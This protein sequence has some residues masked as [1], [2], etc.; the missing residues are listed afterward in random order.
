MQRKQHAVERILE[1]ESLTG[2]LTDV[3][4][5]ALIDWAVAQVTA[6][7]EHPG[8]SDEALRATTQAVRHAVRDAARSGVADPLQLVA[9]AAQNLAATALVAMPPSAAVPLRPVPELP[10]AAEPV[11]PGA[12]PA[13]GTKPLAPLRRSQDEAAGSSAT[14]PR[15]TLDATL[16]RR[17]S[18][19]D[20]PSISWSERLRA[21][22]RK[23]R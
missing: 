2:G 22:L 16:Q 20:Q 10:L 21:W 23:G 1:D 6:R 12:L 17:P 19:P 18:P 5:R 9:C 4:A 8:V 15:P 7:A 14:A 3:P 11:T 13:A